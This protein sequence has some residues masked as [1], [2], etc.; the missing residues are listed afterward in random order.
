MFQVDKWLTVGLHKILDLLDS[1]DMDVRLH[2]AKVV[3]NLAA[4]GW[5]T[6]DHKWNHQPFLH[7]LSKSVFPIF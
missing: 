5:T 3:A 7:S 2:A 1:E 6:N 4:E